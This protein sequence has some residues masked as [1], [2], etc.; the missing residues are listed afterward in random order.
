MVEKKGIFMY[1]TQKFIERFICK[2]GESVEQLHSNEWQIQRWTTRTFRS[3]ANIFA[4][5]TYDSHPIQEIIA[6]KLTP[7]AKRTSLQLS[8]SQLEE[9]LNQGW[10][11]EEV[12]FKKD[13]RTP[14]SLVYRMG[15]GLFAYEQN[16]KRASVEA[17][18]ELKEILQHE[19]N[20]AADGLPKTFLQNAR[21]FIEEEKD[22]ESWGKE[23]IEKFHHFLI[24]FLRLRQEKSRMEYKEIGATYYRKIGGSKA[25]DAYKNV[26]IERMETWVNAPIRELGIISLGTIVPVYFSGNMTGKYVSYETG[27]VHATTDVAIANEQFQTSARILWLVENRA[28]V[29]RMASEVDF[30]KSSKSFVLGVDGQ[31]RGAQ[32]KMIQQLCS[33]SHM[34]QVMIWV[35]YDKAG[36]VIARDLVRL[37]DG[38]PY[39]IVGNEGNVF[40]T[41]E[42]YVD[43]SQTVTQAEQ[44]MT[45]GGVSE[46]KK[47]ISK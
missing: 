30:M 18:R 28:V 3:K 22:R 37:I 25:F 10:I 2:S 46:W 11:I 20:H 4:V 38:L 26:F 29:T 45:L 16:K 13:G 33:R 36:Q 6:L 47:W 23:R 12:R 27:T 19:L 8:A 24:A 42:E 44:E 39:R 34:K 32:R 31:V 5:E 40:S 21:N 7:H 17:M 1:S 43:W 41:Y 35:D 9:A 15:P 14:D